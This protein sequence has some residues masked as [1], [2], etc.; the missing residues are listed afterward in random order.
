MGNS[1]L[2]V[3]SGFIIKLV[4]AASFGAHLLRTGYAEAQAEAESM[5]TT[6]LFINKVLELRTIR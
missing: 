1:D 2:T 3:A 5:S 4:T 6:A